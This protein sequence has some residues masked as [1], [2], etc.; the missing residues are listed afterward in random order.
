MAQYPFF[1]KYSFRL[2]FIFLLIAALILA[3]QILI[4]LFLSIMVAYL[5]YPLAKWLENHYIPRI[6]ANLIVIITFII[7][8]AGMVLGLISLA[9]NLTENISDIQVKFQQ[10]LQSMKASAASVTG[11]SESRINSIGQRL[12]Q[13]GQTLRNVLLATVNT[14][15]YVVLIPVY[16][17]LFLFYRNKFRE[18][19][20]MNIS[21]ENRKAADKIINQ[22]A[23][24]VPK[25][26][27]GLIIVCGILAVVNSLGFMLIGVEFA[28]LLGVI[29][30][31]FNLI[32]YLGTILG[33]GIVILFVY[34]TQSSTVALYVLIQFFIIQFY[35]E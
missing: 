7:I 29:A 31:L 12:G 5:L 28:I 11:L 21:A 23:R 17:F 13:T 16:T 22:A 2:I 34:G 4:P 15:M 14:V 1:I 27:K 25:Y 20:F 33:Y 24:V 26:L 6:A 8:V 30:A 19:I 10:N 32:P 18:F 9:S 35:R 3:K